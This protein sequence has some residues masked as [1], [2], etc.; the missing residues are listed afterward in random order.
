MCNICLKSNYFL[1]FVER[2]RLPALLFNFCD[3][4]RF[5][6]DSNEVQTKKEN[7]G[8]LGNSATP[9]FPSIF[10]TRKNLCECLSRCRI[11]QIT[12]LTVFKLNEVFIMIDFCNLFAFN[13]THT[14][15]RAHTH[16][17][18]HIHIDAFIKIKIRLYVI[19]CG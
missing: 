4:I 11:Q 17:H 15:G 7:E 13:Y 6:H 18:S 12:E 19:S 10:L 14:V 9:F 16:T 3:E 8:Q 2:R 5:G 1:I